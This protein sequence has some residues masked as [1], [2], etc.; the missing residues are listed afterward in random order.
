MR[1]YVSLAVGALAILAACD[2]ISEEQCQAGD[3]EGLG[4]QDGLNGREASRFNDYV[5][6]CGELGI[7]PNQE[8]YLA[9][10]AVGLQ[11]FCTPRN[12]Y[13]LGREGERIGSV[14]P[15]ENLS[16]L[17]SANTQGRRA[18]RIERSIFQDLKAI[19][20]AEEAIDRLRGTDTDEARAAIREIRARIRELK[21]DIRGD[22]LRLRQLERQSL[23][24][25][26]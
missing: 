20:D 26:P 19:D 2:P 25:L 13:S 18:Y 14:C 5:E 21:Q 24:S 4:L 12:A 8:A 17:Q 3:W 22:E 7:A 16:V 11:S 23:A 6:I 1:L 10:R 15:A 9:S